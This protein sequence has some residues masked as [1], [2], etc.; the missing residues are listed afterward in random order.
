MRLSTEEKN[1]LNLY[2]KADSNKQCEALRILNEN[3][4]ICSSITEFFQRITLLRNEAQKS[5]KTGD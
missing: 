2:R 1:L 3:T 5:E 4:V